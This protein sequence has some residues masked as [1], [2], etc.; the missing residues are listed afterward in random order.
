MPAEA[1]VLTDNPAYTVADIRFEHEAGGY[2]TIWFDVEGPSFAE[3]EAMRNLFI[4][5]GD[6]LRNLKEQQPALHNALTE[7]RVTEQWQWLD[8]LDAAGFDWNEHLRR[9]ID[10]C[11]DLEAA[12]KERLGWLN[13]RRARAADPTQLHHPA[14]W[15]EQAEL[16]EPDAHPT[17]D[18]VAHTVIERLNDTAMDLY[19]E[20]L[21][22]SAED[23][24]RLRDIL[25]SHGERL[26]NQLFA[27]ARTVRQT[28]E[29]V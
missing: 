11:L 1:S 16:S 23:N 18:D 24:Q 20:L 15:L 13:E 2:V 10:N 12:E 7:N 27:L 25:E 22:C 4:G 8:R 9:Y 5:F 28:R 29:V 14:D 26:A 6:F 3:P 21:D 17:W 19:P